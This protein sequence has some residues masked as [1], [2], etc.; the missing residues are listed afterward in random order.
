MDVVSAFLAATLKEEIY[1]K[2]PDK[3]Q[4]TFSAYVKILK[5]I[6]RLKQAARIWY[7]LIS[8]FL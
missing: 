1:I 6:Y 8:N 7:L 3:L 5:S 2:V 4:S